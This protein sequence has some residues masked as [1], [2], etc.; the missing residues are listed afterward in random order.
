MNITRASTEPFELLKTAARS[1]IAGQRMQLAASAANP[2]N[3][4]SL[5][6]ILGG[7]KLIDFPWLLQ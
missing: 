6:V 2:A 1:H 5:F 7:K 3:C 4:D